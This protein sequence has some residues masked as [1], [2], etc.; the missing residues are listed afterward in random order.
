MRTLAVLALGLLAS[1][2]DAQQT[3]LAAIFA[4]RPQVMQASMSPDGH[5]VAMIMPGKGR[6]HG[7][8]IV[9]LATGTLKPIYAVSGDGDQISDCSWVGNTRLACTVWGVVQ[10]ETQLEAY[11]QIVAMDDTGANT[12]VLSRGQSMDE[13]YTTNNGGQI[14]DLLPDQ[15]GSVLMTRS[16]APESTTG[17]IV[18]RDRE[19]LGVD[20]VE[21]RNGTAHAIQAPDRDAVEFITD[22]HGQ[23][24]VRGTLNTNQEG[25]SK[26][27]IIYS[28]RASDSSNWRPL[29]VRNYSKMTGFEPYA[30]DPKLNVAYGL[31][32]VSG[33]DA[34]VSYKLD[35]TLARSLV[36]A[37][38]SVDVGGLVTIG[39]AKRVIGFSYSTER[40]HTDYFDPDMKSLQAKLVK[41]LGGDKDVGIVDTSGDERKAIVWSGS[42][43]DPGRFYVLDRN[44]N[45]LALLSE[46]NPEL[47]GVVLSPTQSITYPA[48]DGTRIPA[49]LTLPKNSSGKNLPA[50]VLPHGG[51]ESR[52]Y[53]GFD[54]LSQYFVAR[55]FAVIQPEYR[56]SAG[57]GSAWYQQNGF[58]G[59]RTSIGDVNDAGH[60]LIS[61]GIAD[62][63]KL[64]IFGWSYGGYAAL[65]ANV[66]EPG[67][68]K[69]AVAVAPVTDLGALRASRSNSVDY[70][71]EQE[72][73]IS[74]NNVVEGSPARNA[75]KIQVPVL[76]FHG[77]YDLNVPVAQS[78]LM[79]ARLL[80]AGRRSELVIFDK[81]D[82]QLNDPAAL[83]TV[84]Q[85][86]GDFL[87]TVGK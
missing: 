49:Y 81:L 21:T 75:D 29:S 69:A 45:K 13:A 11:S 63:S 19:G 46:S 3:N 8:V 77:T 30:V 27:A 66:L 33:R 55:G 14:I 16:Y 5:Q 4:A 61:S 73:L 54:I 35:G 72:R 47:S 57:F 18:K 42:D 62:P 67:L 86:S 84:L 2:A 34:L 85:R 76:M 78:K 70:L 65:Q 23:L 56:G 28:Y 51:P 58:R 39:R 87:A 53:W 48:K 7:V 12:K 43:T 40:T 10:G 17:T 22:G 38:P 71:V 79:N 6:A 64:V 15:E 68:F 74:G 1:T 20:R 50:I 60:Y 37:H 24:R 32:P 44:S 52:D 25:Y 31:E 83:Q 36:F 59:W 82:H 41:A 9:D 80:A 26:G